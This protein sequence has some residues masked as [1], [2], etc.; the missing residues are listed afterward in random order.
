MVCCIFL[1]L[2]N[3]LKGNRAVVTIELKN[4][5]QLRGTY[6]FALLSSFLSF[7]CSIDSVDQFLNFKLGNVEVV[8]K[9]RFP[10]LIPMTSCFVRGSVIRYIHLTKADINEDLLLSISLWNDSNS[11]IPSR[12]RRANRSRYYGKRKIACLFNQ[13]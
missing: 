3:V 13:K 2:F 12:L 9:D 4:D 11:S 6:P 10:H 5:V 7:I 8:N 1:S